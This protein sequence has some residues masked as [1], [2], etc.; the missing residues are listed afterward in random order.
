MFLQKVHVKNK[1]YSQTNR[2]KFRCLLP[3]L[4]WFYRGFGCFSATGVQK[5]NKNLFTKKI[6]SKSFPKNSAKKNKT[7][8]LSVLFI[9][10]LGVSRRGEVEKIHLAPGGESPQ[11]FRFLIARFVPSCLVLPGDPPAPFVFRLSSF[12]S[13]KR[14]PAGVRSK[15]LLPSHSHCPAGHGVF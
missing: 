3:R 15:R 1:N 2:Q 6:V 9:A 11:L 7:D 12:A 5:H 14:K 13:R 8:F 10:F 4:L